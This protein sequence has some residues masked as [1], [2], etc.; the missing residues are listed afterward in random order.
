[1]QKL[2]FHQPFMMNDSLYCHILKES[3]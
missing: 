1:M 2:N 3:F